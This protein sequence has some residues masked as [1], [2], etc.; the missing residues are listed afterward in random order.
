M[1]RLSNNPF[2]NTALKFKFSSCCSRYQAFN[3]NWQE[4]LRKI[5]QGSYE[6]H[7]FKAN[8]HRREG[9]GSIR[10]APRSDSGSRNQVYEAYVEARRACGQDV[11]NLTPARLDAVLKKQE[12]TLRNRYGA[13]TEVHFRVVVE[14]GRA[15]LKASREAD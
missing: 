15:K 13:T 2:Q 7:Q 8:L 3:R 5:E 9:P 4:T 12:Q 14:D 10:P 1:A 6:R 11:E